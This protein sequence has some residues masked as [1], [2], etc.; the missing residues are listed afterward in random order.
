MKILLIYPYCLEE[1]IN[2]EEVSH[3][4][5]GVYYIGAVLKEKGYDVEILNCHG[6]DKKKRAIREYIKRSRPELI[7]FSILNANRWGGIEI[8][9]MAKEVDPEITV[10]F[11]GVGATFLW[12]L[13]LAHFSSIDAVVLGEGEYAFL[14]IAD[15]VHGGRSKPLEGIE[16]IALRKGE[17]VFRTEAREP[18]ADLDE[19]PIP[20]EY[21]EYNHITSSRGCPNNC[22]FCGSPRFWGRRVRFHSAGYLVKQL[23]L[24]VKKGV[25]FFFFSDDTFTIKNP[26]V[27]EICRLII[28][29]GLSIS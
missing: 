20:A 9:R 22:S 24:L 16:G 14:E 15:W 3:V 13:F 21:F 10:V 1:R 27:I 17:M 29:Q 19:L 11:G 18:I 5:I 4:P 28:D 26:R 7:G 12:E 25:S 2:Q 23:E 8:S 6:M